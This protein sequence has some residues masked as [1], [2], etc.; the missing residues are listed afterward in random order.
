MLL[1]PALARA[2]AFSN[3]PPGSP[4][5]P[6]TINVGTSCPGVV[7]NGVANDTTA[8]VACMTT[9][10]NRGG[11]VLMIPDAKKFLLDPI[12]VPAHVC[13]QGERAGPFDGAANPATTVNAPTLLINSYASTFITLGFDTCL[14]D[15]LIY[16]PGQVAPT[17]ATPTTEPAFVTVPSTSGGAVSI[18]RNTLVNAYA[19]INALGGKV[20][21]ESNKIGAYSYAISVDDAADWVFEKDNLIEPFYD[22]YLAL[23]WPQTIDTWVMNNGA[24]MILRRVD[25]VVSFGNGIIYKNKCVLMDDTINGAS[26]FTAGYGTITDLTCDT[27]S[28]GFYAKSTNN[29]GFGYQI[30]N[31]TINGNASGTGTTGTAAFATVAGGTETPILTVQGGSINGSWSATKAISQGAGTLTVRNVGGI[32][33]Y[34]LVTPPAVPGTGVGQVNT[35]SA[36]MR[37]FVS[38]NGATIAAIGINGTPTGLI[39]GSF[40]VLVGDTITLVYSGGTPSWTWFG[41]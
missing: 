27:V 4:T 23:T 2:D 12:S 35:F 39:T 10:S 30:L 34:G 3:T 41:I 11:G 24:G 9:L 36:D 25:K 32:N 5:S 1:A 7:G 29:T 31:P 40:T 13:I 33:P 28:Y 15:V 8:V 21:I 19:G 16:D 14:Q 37:V 6:T 18:R 17:I 22:T 38:A 26:G 20:Y